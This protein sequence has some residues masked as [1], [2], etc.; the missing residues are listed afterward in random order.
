MSKEVYK[1]E[2]CIIFQRLTVV[3]ADIAFAVVVYFFTSH[4]VNQYNAK[5]YKT[6]PSYLIPVGLLLNTGLVLVD[7]IHF[8][9]NSLLFTI[10]LASV[11]AILKVMQF[12][13]RKIFTK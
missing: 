13:I 6:N 2:Q 12:D 5:K 1:A 9:Y 3:F 4:F 10:F 7:N 11:L 8:F